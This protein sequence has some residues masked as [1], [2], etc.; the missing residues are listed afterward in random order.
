MKNLLTI[1][2]TLITITLSAQED[3]SLLSMLDDDNTVDYTTA[4]FKTNRVINL[5]S[6]EN[7]AAGVWDFK[8]SH[9]FGYVNNGIYDLFGI[10]A[11][12]Q[13][14]G[15]DIGITDNF[16]VGFNRNSVDKAYDVY[17]K[18]RMLRQSTGAKSMPITLSLLTSAAI[19]T[20]RWADPT[21]NNLSSSRLFYTHQMIVGRKFNDAFTLQ[22]SPTIVH[23]NLVASRVEKNT[24]FAMGVA[25]RLKLSNRIALTGEY[26]WVAP[27]QLAAGLQNSVSIGF[28]IETGGHVFQLHFTNSSSMSEY[29]FITNNTG[30]ISNGDIR[31]GFNVSR[32]FTLWDP[33]AQR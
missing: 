20:T 31:F 17:M 32:V 2:I 1:F 11:A 16:Q 23:R 28:D 4:S 15:G 24:V 33:K 18:Y 29:G 21:R 6:L 10:D 26:I 22:L 25:G 12:T 7:T 14:I 5:H 27:N 13:R 8:I 9:R 3:S 19:T 30:K